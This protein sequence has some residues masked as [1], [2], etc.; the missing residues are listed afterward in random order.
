MCCGVLL[1]WRRHKM[2]MIDRRLSRLESGEGLRSVYDLIGRFFDELTGPERE[3]WTRYRFNVDAATV[4]EVESQVCGTLH[5][6]C[7]RRPK[8]PTRAE[9]TAITTEIERFILGGCGNE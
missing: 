6:V 8:E 1:T 9:H 5:F 3:R 7:D 4:A 2:K